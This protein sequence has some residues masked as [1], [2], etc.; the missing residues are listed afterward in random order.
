MN[1][2]RSL[3]SGKLQNIFTTKRC[4]STTYTTSQQHPSNLLYHSRSCAQ[5]NPNK[6]HSKLRSRKNFHTILWRV[7]LELAE[8]H[9]RQNLPGNDAN[10]ELADTAKCSRWFLSVRTLLKRPARKGNGIFKISGL[11]P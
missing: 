2:D 3:K 4:N 11:F 6:T 1:Q 10:D 7:F 5:L 8:V 9:L